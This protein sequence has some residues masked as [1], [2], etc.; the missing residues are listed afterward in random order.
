M[1]ASKNQTERP[2]RHRIEIK[3]SEDQKETITRGASLAKQ[4]VSE[5]VRS[6]AEKAARD[7]IS[8]HR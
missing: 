6:V 5:F 1:D 7:L 8:K 3:L 4:G 2:T